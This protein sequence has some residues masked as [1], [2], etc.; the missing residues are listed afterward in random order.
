MGSAGLTAPLI[1]S[2]KACFR[3]DQ[4]GS[5]RHHGGRLQLP[6]TAETQQG[7]SHPNI[8]GFKEP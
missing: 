4:H 5:L 8:Q 2:I 3:V 6:N 7:P 1:S